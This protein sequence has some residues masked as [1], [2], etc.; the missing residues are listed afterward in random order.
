VRYRWQEPR[1]ARSEP[2]SEREVRVTTTRG[3]PG[4]AGYGSINQGVL[5]ASNVDITQELLSMVTAQQAY[6]GNSRALQTESEM[7]RSVT[8][9]LIK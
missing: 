2:V 3:G 5:E 8:E 1:Y 4:K 9:T 7:L 6:N